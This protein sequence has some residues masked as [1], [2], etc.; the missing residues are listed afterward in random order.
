MY[1]ALKKELS[2]RPMTPAAVANPWKMGSL[3]IR[4]KGQQTDSTA[5]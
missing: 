1:L 2:Q 5:T 4:E 3:S